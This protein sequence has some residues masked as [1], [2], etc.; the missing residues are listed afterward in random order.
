MNF[1]AFV[2]AL[3]A[4]GTVACGSSTTD[5]IT[6]YPL[7]GTITGLA[8]QL[9]LS[10]GQDTKSFTANGAFTFPTQLKS[11]QSYTVSITAQPDHQQCTLASASGTASA[12]S[13]NAVQVTCVSAHDLGGT[14]SG[15]DA[16]GTLVLTN[17][18]ADP[19]TVSANGNFHF[20]TPVLS[21]SNYVVAVSQQP[22]GQTCT[23][24]T[25]SGNI[26]DAD[27]MGAAVS[28]TENI[29]SVG[30]Q[31][32]G[33]ATNGNMVLTNNQT[34]TLNIVASGSF[35]F[36][37]GVPHNSPYSVAVT[38]QPS[39][40][41]CAVSG[42][43][44]IVGDANLTSVVV[45]CNNNLYNVTGTLL[46]LAAGG[47]VVLLDNNTDSLQVAANGAFTFATQV[48]Y[49]GSY[50]VSVGTQPYGQTCSVSSTSN[51]VG[52][53][54]VSVTVSCSNNPFTLGG[55]VAGLATNGN[56]KVANGTDIATV[57]ANGSFTFTQP[58]NY[59]SNYGV[60]VSTQ[61]VGQTCGV[62]NPNG[63]M[64]GNVTNVAVNCNN[65]LYTVGGTLSGLVANTNV[66][67]AN[68]TTDTRTLSANGAF[69][70]AT[71]VAYMGNYNVVITQQPQGQTCTLT[72]ASGA[73]PAA[74]VTSVG[75]ACSP[76]N[77][78][79]GV[80]VTGLAAGQTLT[81]S[82]GSSLSVTAN[83]NTNFATPL[84]YGS[85][86]SVSITGQPTTQVC[87]IT[88]GGT[89][90]T[91]G[92]ANNVATSITC[93]TAYNV[94]GTVTGLNGN[95]VLSDGSSQTVSLTTGASAFTFAQRYAANATYTVSVASQPVGQ[96]CNVT[97]GT[98]TITNANVTNVAVACAAFTRLANNQNAVAWAGQTAANANAANQGGAAA[99]GTLNLPSGS[100]YVN[101]SKMYVADT[102]NNRVLAYAA[103]PTTGA[104]GNA[105]FVLGQASGAYT[106]TGSATSAAGMF[107]PSTPGLNGAT[108]FAVAD[109]NNNRIL[110]YTGVPTATASAVS[111]VGQATATTRASGC[112]GT[113]LNAPR[114]A[115][116]T[117]SGLFVV[118]DTNNNRVLIW[119]TAASAVGGT[120]A[121]TFVLGQSAATTCTAA[122]TVSAS[123][124]NAP[125]SLWAD[126]TRL[127]VA[128]TGNNRV[129]IYTLSGLATGQ[130]ASVI[131]GQSTVSGAAAAT[132]STG[133][134]SPKAVFGA[135][136]QLFVAD[137]GNNRVLV[138][139]SIPTAN[140]AAA[141]V[142]LGQANL[143]TGTANTGGTTAAALS[144]PTGVTVSGTQFIVTDTGNSRVLVYN[145]N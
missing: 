33:L 13:V 81:V 107:Q 27:Y 60:T 105:S 67:V 66:V 58:V 43:N 138:Y 74:N 113:T 4:T 15:L 132:T 7:G 19:T 20:A 90:L 143:N 94:G 41:T 140:G 11:D 85:T 92:T 122:A 6:T 61:P 117:P 8:G 78:P 51:T 73:V 128:D 63:T 142:V 139:N 120:T 97:N 14:V 18:G 96:N 10:D 9:T 136:G 69:T 144:G 68:N 54:D 112:T 124:L 12:S 129:L 22:S 39:G 118:A 36:G 75:L 52:A 64:N 119:N 38:K 49:T 23:V 106:A 133:L 123:T 59:Q 91:V 77:Y 50:A 98:G 35:S 141:S 137:T 86:Y 126:T 5:D 116:T 65:N 53:G 115:I 48:Q 24:A 99:Q 130:A 111:F 93:S 80:N 29:Y 135:N 17:N 95:I 45:N 87:S 101:A 42:G 103:V 40:Q 57:L 131:I 21:N 70:F 125:T 26:G 121:A 114:H 134:S 47:N 34:S 100:V 110:V 28:C 25:G 62:T 79:V 109:T 102:S 104:A 32:V 76:N 82:D 31:V 46:G 84:A 89:N 56:V 71:S 55:T 16:G 1:R 88:S 30:G 83:G 37:D 44:G 3:V 108:N 72:G 145:S 2:F 127:Y